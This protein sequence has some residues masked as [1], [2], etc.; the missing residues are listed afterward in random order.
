M[1]WV[2]SRINATIRG[3]GL[4]L[5]NEPTEALA[6][7]SPPPPTSPS[8]AKRARRNRNR[9]QQEE[10]KRGGQRSPGFVCWQGLHLRVRINW[11]DFVI[12]HALACRVKYVRLLQRPATSERASGADAFGCCY[13]VQ[14]VVERVPLHKPKHMIGQGVVGADLGPSS[15]A[16]VPQAGEARLD[17]FC[18][19]LSPKAEHGKVVRRLQRKLDRQRRAANPDNYDEKGRVK[20]GSKKHPLH[21]KHSQGEQHTCRRLA[22]KARKR[23]AHRKS[24]HGKL[25]YEIVAMGNTVILEKISYRAWQK[26]FG[27]SVSERAP[28]S[29][30]AHLK[31]LVASTGGTLVE[32]NTRTTRLSQFCHGCGAMV[33]KPL[34]QRFHTCSCGIGPIQRD[35]YSAFLAAYLDIS[36]PEHPQP[37]ACGQYVIP[38]QGWEASLSAAH[39][40]VLQR[41]KDGH[42]L[43]GSL[44]LARARV[45]RRESQS[46]PLLEPADR[47][48]L[49]WRHG[50]LKRRVGCE[51][52]PNSI[53][54]E[55]SVYCIYLVRSHWDNQSVS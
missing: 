40:V 21:W 8:A 36:D 3:C 47:P 22:T 26:Q 18:A 2:L 49:R 7:C 37:P 55:L 42:D 6:T 24:L 38:W 48:L 10:R 5:G 30:V 9:L 52:P 41:A 17:V 13:A 23:A 27:K 31:R 45:R 43:P 32:I 53:C 34:S 15:Y 16:V 1:G 29:F 39:A 19:E 25:A 4:S 50:R 51:N 12:A 14:L 44:G 28:G 35:L 11:D 46:D 54:G 33:K 20:R